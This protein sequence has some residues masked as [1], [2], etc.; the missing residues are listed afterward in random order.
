MAPRTRPLMLAASILLFLSSLFSAA[1]STTFTLTNS[2]AYTVWPGLLSGSGTPA[3]PTTGF[4]LAPGESR[5]VEAP[6]AWSG[7]M[8]GRTLCATG[9]DGRFACATCDCGSGAVECAGGGAAPPCSL[10]EFTLAGSGGNDFYDVSLVDGSNIPMAVLPQGGS[11]AGC[12]ATGCLAD[13]NGPCPAD[14]RVAGP[15][16]A[17]IA[18]K[19]AC[20]AFGRPEDCCSGAFAGGP[21]A[22][23]PSAYSMFFKNA[24]PRAY[25]YAYDD[26]TSTF[27]CASGTA[28]YLVVF[29]PTA[30]SSSDGESSL[31][32]SVVSTNPSP[33]LPHVNDTVSYLGRSRDAGSGWQHTPSSSD[34]SSSAP[35]PF[36]IAVVAVFTWLCG[37]SAGRQWPLLSS[38]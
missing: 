8:W 33:A 28:A 12:A 18:C 23:R 24:C 7:R 15:D 20:E 38:S 34:A 17:G 10:A 5:A 9:A 13:L 19:S 30:M 36:A 35:S 32:S 11:G 4:A 26:A 31:K 3:L 25:S 16:G 1:F 21:E 14:L 37:S 2:C 27:T 22:C 29:C 6:A